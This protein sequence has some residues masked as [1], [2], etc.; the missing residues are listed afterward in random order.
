MVHWT[1]NA[2]EYQEASLAPIP[3][4]DHRVRIEEVDECVSKTGKDMLKITLKVSGF[5]GK[6]FYYL[7]FDPG[8]TQMTNKNLGDLYDSFNIPAGSMDFHAWEGQVG[9]ARV[10]HEDYNGDPR[11]SVA[12]FIRR[13]R[14][15]VLPAWQ[16]KP[17]TGMGNGSASS[18]VTPSG[19]WDAKSFRE[20]PTFTSAEDETGTGDDANIPF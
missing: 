10:K 6:L 7:V 12:W 17:T 15:E 19:G 14:Q 11:A 5:N 4:G 16:E 13:S 18:R 2:K 3:V 20:D 1:Y 8:N 9:A